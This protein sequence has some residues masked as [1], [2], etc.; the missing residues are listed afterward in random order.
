MDAVQQ[1]MLLAG[2]SHRETERAIAGNFVCRK[3]GNY[4]DCLTM[5][6]MVIRQVLARMIYSHLVI[7]SDVKVVPR[8]L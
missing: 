8:H 4:F 2:N 6:F 1:A 5:R 3:V 7:L